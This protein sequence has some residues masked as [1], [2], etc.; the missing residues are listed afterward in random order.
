[1]TLPLESVRVL[2]LTRLLPG[3]YCTMMLA[4][5]GAEVI[6]VETPNI[7]DY[8]RWYEPRI[9]KNGAMFH[10]LNR[11]KKSVALNLKSEEGK[12]IFL[13][14]VEDADVV[15]ESFRPG[16][17]D[18]LGI[19]YDVLKGVNPG[20][21]FCAVTGYG[22]TGPYMDQPGHDINYLSY[23]GLLDLQGEQGGRPSVPATQIADLGGGAFPAA[24]GILLALYERQQSG[25]GQ[26]VDIAMLDG[27]ISW[28]Q[29]ILP[30]YL[31]DG[32]VPERGELPLSGGKACYEVY[33]T[34]DGRYLSVGALEPKFWRSFCETIGK[35]AFIPRLMAPLREQNRMKAEIQD[36]ISEK[37]LAEWLDRFSNVEAC[38]TPVQN[39]EE[40]MQDPQVIA[41]EM[42]QTHQGVKQ[43]GQPIKLSETP[44]LIRSHAPDLGE[45][46]DELLQNIGYSKQEID[47]FKENKVIG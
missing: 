19:G 35:E 24:V 29:T 44:A 13:K 21:V 40:M 16:V 26:F 43:P 4:D 14:L 7:G 9:D 45:H 28:L 6:K 17:M 39:L 5:F 27:V 34:R 11:N 3:P 22:Q 1:M 10:S 33:E 47:T 31:A 12:T 42:M 37:T 36:V 15:V 20:L 38:V 23:A 18:R 41:R 25:E 2:D 30:D 32:N 46:T 8:A